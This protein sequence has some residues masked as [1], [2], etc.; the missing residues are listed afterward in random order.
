M[1]KN[2]LILAFLGWVL[3][4]FSVQ[5]DTKHQ[6]AD[7]V[8]P[9]PAT[10]AAQAC[11][12]VRSRIARLACF[13]DAFNTVWHIISDQSSAVVKPHAWQRAYASERSRNT[14]SQAFLLN[15][16][17]KQDPQQGLWLTAQA[18]GPN[19]LAPTL[20]LSCIDNISRV[21]LML[22]E[23]VDKARS[24]VTLGNATSLTQTWI[25]DDSGYVIRAGRGLSSILAMKVFI[26][27][28]KTLIRSDIPGF[29]LLKFDTRQLA[30]TVKPMRELCRW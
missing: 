10:E 23:A 27:S 15:Y 8:T 30:Q 13:D 19:A 21:E 2:W 17:D 6:A 26:G 20:L 1:K 3:S 24:T 12:E 7:V 14:D 4:A 25:L 11:A 29:E 22:P 28:D 5:A 16:R 18:A 9:S